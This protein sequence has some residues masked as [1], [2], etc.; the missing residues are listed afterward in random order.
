MTKSA[1]Y[2]MRHFVIKM[3]LAA[4][5]LCAV[6]PVLPPVLPDFMLNL[7]YIHDCFGLHFAVYCNISFSNESDFFPL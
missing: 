4:F 3:K 5:W 7:C 6:A 2:I 1:F